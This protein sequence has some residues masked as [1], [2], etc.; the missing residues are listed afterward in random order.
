VIVSRIYSLSKHRHCEALAD[1]HRVRG[2]E[3]QFPPECA[4]T[5]LGGSADNFH[6]LNG[7]ST[8]IN[9]HLWAMTT[10]AFNESEEIYYRDW[11]EGDPILLKRFDEL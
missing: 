5:D 9:D 4:R 6:I 2:D 1:Q 7:D 11:L 8:N 3:S 10:A